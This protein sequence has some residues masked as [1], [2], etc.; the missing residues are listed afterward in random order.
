M[1]GCGIK[2]DKDIEEFC[3]SYNGMFFICTVQMWIMSSGM[4]GKFS[5]PLIC[6]ASA[7]RQVFFMCLCVDCRSG[8]H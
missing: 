7:V 4:P 2:K 8:Q 6:I 5:G 3:I 1:Y